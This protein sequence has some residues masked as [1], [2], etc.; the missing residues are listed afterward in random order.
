MH[1]RVLVSPYPNAFA[2]YRKSTGFSSPTIIIGFNDPDSF[3]MLELEVSAQGATRI[4][5][6]EGKPIG[7]QWEGS[8]SCTADNYRAISYVDIGWRGFD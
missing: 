3:E 7:A 6:E 5:D 4:V 1:Y 8:K 2:E